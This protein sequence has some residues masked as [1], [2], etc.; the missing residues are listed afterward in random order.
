MME[1]KI[2]ANQ[3]LIAKPGRSAAQ[4]FRT[5]PFTTNV[6]KPKVSTFMGKVRK[7]RIGHNTAFANPM[8]AAAISAET[9]PLIANPFT[10]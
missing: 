5:I 9:K 8:T 1:P 7:I 10:K 4:I 3:V 6:N 2:A